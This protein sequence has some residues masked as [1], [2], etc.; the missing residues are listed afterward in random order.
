MGPSTPPEPTFEGPPEAVTQVSP[1]GGEPPGAEPTP[2]T[3][4]GTPP[5][6]G[7]PGA[8]ERPQPRPRRRRRILRAAATFALAAVVF[9]GG[10]AVDRVVLEPATAAPAVADPADF[11]LIQEAWQL[12]HQQYVDRSSLDGSKMAHSAI[13]GM[14][15]AV[16]DPGHTSFLTPDE[17]ALSRAVLNGSFVGIGAELDDRSGSPVIVGVVPGGPADKA[18][19]RAGD[20]LVAV[21][22]TPVGTTAIDAVVAH[23]RGAEGTSVT[24]TVRHPGAS[25]DTMIKIQRAKIELDPV[26]WTRIPNTSDALVR[27]EQFSSGAT[28]DLT[29]AIGAIRQAKLTGIVLDLRADPGGLVDEAIGVASQFLASGNVYVQQD[30]TGKQTAVPVRSGG[31]ATDLPLVVVV[32]NST[33]SASE[34]VAGAIQDAGRARVVGETTF[35]TGTVLAE[36]DL[37]DGSALRIGTIQWL[38][39]K[40]RVIWRHGITPDVTVAEP[41]NVSPLTP[42]AVQQGTAITK[43]TDPQL[44]AALSLLPTA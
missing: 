17:V 2:V 39:P 42:R 1:A 16:D 9:G 30:A 21:D 29:D 13:D 15:N 38:T 41:T 28:K 26:S 18:G 44:F 12:L 36:F 33:A 25:A 24:L 8:A 27:I 4:A 14:T 10:V 5:A 32:D 6:T 35:G 7:T 31:A 22:G 19:V 34:I 40:G 23:I 37:A 11:A 20:T 43:T 3:A